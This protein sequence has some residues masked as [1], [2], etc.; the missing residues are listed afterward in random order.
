MTNTFPSSILSDYS[1][2]DNLRL[3][4]LENSYHRTALN[5]TQLASSIYKSTDNSHESTFKL[6]QA[7]KPYQDNS[8][9]TRINSFRNLIKFKSAVDPLLTLLSLGGLWS[10]NCEEAFSAL[11]KCRME[12]V[13]YICFQSFLCLTSS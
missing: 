4:V 6:I 5:L 2:R 9:L 8:K 11:I 1:C 13:C 3:L 10:E 7:V 12:P